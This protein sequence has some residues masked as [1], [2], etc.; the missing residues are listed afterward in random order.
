MISS[1]FWALVYP[2][3]LLA[4]P[5]RALICCCVLGESWMDLSLSEESETLNLKLELPLLYLEFP[6][7]WEE[8]EE[9]LYAS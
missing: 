5:K 3:T 6:Y 8:E 2:K 9:L 7:C 4:A 1:Y